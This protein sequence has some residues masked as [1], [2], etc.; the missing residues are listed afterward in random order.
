MLG[1][2]VAYII[3]IPI[4]TYE[5]GYRYP[6]PRNLELAI[7]VGIILIFL[8]GFVWMYPDIKDY[9]N[10]KKEKKDQSLNMENPEPQSS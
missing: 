10:W 5:V 1:T 9:R 3:V 2:L 7:D 6:L 8:L 4:L